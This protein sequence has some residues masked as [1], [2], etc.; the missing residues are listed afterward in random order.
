MTK[1]QQSKTYRKPAQSSDLKLQLGEI[2]LYGN[3]QRKEFWPL[4][5][6]LLRQYIDLKLCT[7]NA[8]ETSE[9]SNKEQVD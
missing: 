2:L 7:K 3:V 4:F 5:D 6:D 1:K 8:L 9:R